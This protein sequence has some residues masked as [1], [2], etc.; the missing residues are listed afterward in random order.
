[1]AVKK[2]KRG[3]KLGSN[4]D[5]GFGSKFDATP[6]GD[7]DMDASNLNGKRRQMPQPIQDGQKGLKKL[8]AAYFNF[9][10]T[11]FRNTPRYQQESY[12]NRFSQ[13][14]CIGISAVILN[15]FYSVLLP[16]VRIIS[17]P[18]IVGLAWYVANKVVAPVLI[19]RMGAY[20]ND[21]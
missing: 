2:S 17:L 19:K 14:V 11:S 9:L 21:D 15:S 5:D 16:Q 8:I 7:G 12:I 18:I 6:P 10:R 4:V 3:G 20:M 13:I 1:M